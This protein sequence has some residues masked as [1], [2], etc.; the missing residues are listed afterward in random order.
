LGEIGR[1]F[2]ERD[3]ASWSGLL[4]GSRKRGHCLCQEEA[5]EGEKR[6]SFEVDSMEDGQHGGDGNA[7]Q[8]GAHRHG[9]F[10]LVL[11]GFVGH[12]VLEKE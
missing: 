8:S 7:Y 5:E 4:S 12:C 2:A 3:I 1:G 9:G 10:Q 6:R 11:F